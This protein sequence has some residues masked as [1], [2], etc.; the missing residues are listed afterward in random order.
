M[1]CAPSTGLY[2]ADLET[3]NAKALAAKTKA[4]CARVLKERRLPELGR[5]LTEAEVAALI[6]YRGG[7]AIDCAEPAL[8]YVE[9]VTKTHR[10]LG[11]SRRFKRR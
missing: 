4:N 7:M 5:D 9:H 10:A 2:L 11:K 8:A 6:A 1:S 3:P